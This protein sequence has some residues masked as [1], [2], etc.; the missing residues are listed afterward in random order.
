M[1]LQETV[2]YSNGQLQV[3]LAM[4]MCHGMTS[5]T[6]VG[7]PIYFKMIFGNIHQYTGH[8]GLSYSAV[9]Q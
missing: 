3:P 5:S 1:W 4:I 2:I 8:L 7:I 6:C 9:S